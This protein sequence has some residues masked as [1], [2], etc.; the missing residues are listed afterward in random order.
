[1]DEYYK[2]LELKRG[3]SI[4][5]IKAAK[6]ELLQKWHPDY[7][8]RNPELAQIAEERTKLINDAYDKLTEYLKNNWQPPTR[9]KKSPANGKDESNTQTESARQQAE[10]ERQQREKAEQERVVK[11][12]AAKQEWIARD[13]ARQE[14]FR[15]EQRKRVIKTWLIVLCVLL[16]LLLPGGRWF[17]TTAPAKEIYAW[18]NDPHYYALKL[19]KDWVEREIPRHHEIHIKPLV[20]ETE[21]EVRFNGD[22]ATKV[23]VTKERKF[24]NGVVLFG[25]SSGIRFI[26][27]RAAQP[28][29]VGK[30]YYI[31][32]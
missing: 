5:E 20:P 18:W 30:P 10:Q 1:M 24:F 12:R 32:P 15:Q 27:I 14:I 31:W 8:Q 22:D 19:P 29:S 7:F 3:A 13:R 23:I 11:E 17:I 9:P 26:E 16:I 21:I 2:V 25:K 6:H 4:K 28:E